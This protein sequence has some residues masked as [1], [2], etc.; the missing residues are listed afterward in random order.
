M[1]TTSQLHCSK[2]ESDAEKHPKHL[3]A[4]P[5]AVKWLAAALIEVANGYSEDA[6]NDGV[7][8]LRHHGFSL[9]LYKFNSTSFKD[10]EEVTACIAVAFTR[11]PVQWKNGIE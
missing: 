8:I 10:C 7:N 1:S 5:P 4:L 11:P 9:K 2:R 3:L 6:A